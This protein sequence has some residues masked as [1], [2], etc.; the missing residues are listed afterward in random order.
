MVKQKGEIM[1][2]KGLFAGII[3]LIISYGSVTYGQGTDKSPLKYNAGLLMGYNRGFGIQTNLTASNFGPS[4]NAR[5]RLGIGL[6]FLNPG[7]AGDARR[8]FINNATNGVPEKNGR[9]FDFRFDVM[10]PKT[11]FGNSHSFLVLGPRFSTFRGHFD[12]VDG[13]EV[14]DVTSTQWGVGLGIEHQ[15][16]MTEKLALSLAYGLDFYLPSTLTGHDTSYSPNNDNVNPEENDQRDNAPYE[17]RDANKAIA[18]PE[19]MPRF[20]IGLNFNL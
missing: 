18:Q 19:I 12:Y 6:T 10:F 4:F 14:F 16:K 15:F 5:L 3:M 1:K 11:I 8:V 13:N 17:Y 2:I 9:S 20:M 7:N